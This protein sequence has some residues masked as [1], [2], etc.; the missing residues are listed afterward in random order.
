MIDREAERDFC[1][2]EWSRVDKD[3]SVGVVT[4]LMD[5]RASARAERDAEVLALKAENERLQSALEQQNRKIRGMI[6]RVKGLRET[7][8]R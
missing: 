4:W 7:L 6:D 3:K 8:A 1:T 2:R 5:M